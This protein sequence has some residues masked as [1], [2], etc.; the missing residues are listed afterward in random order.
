M[1][2]RHLHSLM[3]SSSLCFARPANRVFANKFI[4]GLRYV[5]LITVQAFLS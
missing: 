1:V 3:D 2:I 4:Y 5:H